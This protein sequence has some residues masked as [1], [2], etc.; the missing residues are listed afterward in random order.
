[1]LFM[2]SLILLG[3]KPAEA[4][5][6]YE[7]LVGFIFEHMADGDPESLSLGLDNLDNWLVGD[8]LLSVEE[9]LVV[10][11][12]P[13]TAVESL[14]GHDHSIDELAG[15]SVLT[16]SQ[17]KPEIITDALTQYSFKTIIPETYI[18]YD[19]NFEDGKNCIVERDCLWAEATAYTV[20]DWGVLGEVTAER[21]IQFRWVETNGGW[22]MLQRWWLT[23]PSTGTRLDL[24]IQDQYY[25]G[26]TKSNGNGSDRVHA[27]WINMKMS[28]GDA[29]EG[30]ANQLITSWKNDAESLDLWIEEQ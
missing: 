18:V 1:M 28:T 20:A 26:V 7:E 16:K 12:L 23:E 3:C 22:V 5:E 24:R 11:T 27:S 4:P 2:S 21:R 19:R 17:F 9:G 25:I 15:V 6:E 10:S 29:S 13:L 30:A 14:D 8:Q